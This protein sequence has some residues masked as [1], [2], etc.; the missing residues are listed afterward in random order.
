MK[1]SKELPSLNG[2]RAIC[3]ALVIGAHEAEFTPGF[4]A[5]WK[6]AA[7][8]LFNGSL[9]VRLFFVLS[10]FLITYL[11]IQ[12]EHKTGGVSLKRFYIRRALRILPVYYA[13]IITV[14]CIDYLLRLDLP[15]REYVTALT[16]TKDFSVDRW[17]LAHLWSL[18]VEEQ[19]YLVWPFVISLCSKRAR[20][21][22]AIACVA[23][24]PVC[25]VILYFIGLSYWGVYSPFTNVDSLMIGSIV[26]MMAAEGMTVLD[27]LLRWRPAVARTIAVV[28][29]Y[30][31]WVGSISQT[32]LRWKL[33][34][35]I[36]P[37]GASVQAL[38]GA[39]LIV[40]YAT[41]RTGAGYSLLNRAWMSYVGVLS[42]SLY[43]W[44]Q[45]ATAPAKTYGGGGWWWVHFPY[46][47]LTIFAVSWCS[48]N[49][50]ELP[51]MQLRKRFRS[52]DVETVPADAKIRAEVATA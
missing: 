40:S 19:F 25:R 11:L 45:L 5:A 7:A 18:S 20:F 1:T 9:G 12:E 48:Y 17:P 29:I 41:Q 42:Y 13:F 31:I 30:A 4:P 22:A 52:A 10:G 8:Y 51:L 27:R 26:G 37:F 49:L 15:V 35:F 24:A 36:L 34:W 3:I 39:Y 32:A 14:V 16:Y 2:I 43:I 28:S 33:G 47:L 46:N 38:A 50:L 44:Q 6:G 23:A 21:Q